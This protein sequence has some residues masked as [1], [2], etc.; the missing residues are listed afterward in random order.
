MAPHTIS[1]LV[2]KAPQ[3]TADHF[4]SQ[5]KTTNVPLMFSLS[6]PGSR[7]L[8]YWRRYAVNDSSKHNP[9]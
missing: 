9:D 4:Q 5:Y 1:I 8:L 7:Q 2:Y 6:N 3:L